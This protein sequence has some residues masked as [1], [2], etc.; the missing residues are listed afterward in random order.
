MGRFRTP[1]KRSHTARNVPLRGF[2]FHP[3]ALS[4][5]RRK[6]K[7]DSDGS[8]PPVVYDKETKSPSDLIRPGT[9]IGI[10]TNE[11][12]EDVTTAIVARDCA[13]VRLGMNRRDSTA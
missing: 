4:S 8:E 1:G 5:T 3:L 11:R 7:I 10:P 2:L 6:T 9:A 13:E 12:N